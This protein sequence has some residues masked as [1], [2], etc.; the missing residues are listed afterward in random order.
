MIKAEIAKNLVAGDPNLM[1][2]EKRDALLE[3]ARAIYDRDHTVTITLRKQDLA[4]ADMMA[5]RIDDLPK[6]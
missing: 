1:A 2:P 4:M 3:A 5:A 6:A